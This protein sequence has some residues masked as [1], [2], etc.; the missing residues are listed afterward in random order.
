[1]N[2]A[3]TAA[4]NPAIPK[5]HAYSAALVLLGCLIPLPVVAT[6]VTAAIYITPFSPALGPIIPAWVA[7]NWMVCI[8]GFVIAL[9]LWLLSAL[10]FTGFSSMESAIPVKGS[11]LK[12]H[13]LAVRASYNALLAME[14]SADPMAQERA[15]GY[16]IASEQVKCYLAELEQLLRYKDLRWI[17]GTGY[18]AAWSLVHRAEEALIILE[19][20]E[21]VIR[22][23]LNDELS[24]E[25]SDMQAREIVLN[26]LR[27]AVANLSA[28]ASMYLDQQPVK[29]MDQNG[30]TAGR[31]FPAQG[32]GPA[33]HTPHGTP[34][35][36]V[37]S[38]PTTN[39]TSART[40]PDTIPA[41]TDRVPQEKV[42][43][44]AAPAA[45]E[46]PVPE[47]RRPVTSSGRQV[48][49]V[50]TELEAR[51]ALREVRQNIHEFRE[52][53]WEGLV[54]IRNQLIGTTIITG[55]PAYVMLCIAILSG[56]AQVSILAA[57]IFFVMG[58]LTGLFGRLYV[59]SKADSAVDDY[60]L[61]LARIV[62][63]PVL[64]GLAAVGG[65]L[66]TTMLSLTVLKLPSLQTS[67]QQL[68]LGAIYNLNSN[69]FGIIVAALFGLTP[70]LFINILQDKA[71]G[72]TDQ[73]QKSTAS[74]LGKSAS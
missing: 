18:L 52:A 65:V 13:F 56:A 39:G 59:E 7:P 25:G 47:D 46:T 11:E 12:N 4:G 29:A 16:H 33:D 50:T 32:T 41:L 20:R 57:T 2:T 43:D 51:S 8:V 54:T 5:S 42:G 73:L 48:I 68:D 26:K 24:L 30:D 36:T 66:L 49:D 74:E 70:N 35:A 64:A 23:A 22:E 21:E 14:N 72:L 62:V 3:G 31:T 37:D 15:Y 45:S 6:I 1:M 71:K 69:T 27:R 10:P 53:L 9:V 28:S 55:L 38:S 34:V 67:N 17:A 44:L 63:T 19:P 40:T 58:A 61:T 60:D